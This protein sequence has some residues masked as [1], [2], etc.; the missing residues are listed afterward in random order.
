MSAYNDIVEAVREGTVEDV[1]YFVEKEKIDVDAW[2]GESEGGMEF[3][4]LEIAAA[5]NSDIGVFEYLIH[6][7]ARVSRQSFALAVM[8]NT[9]EIIT[10]LI[11]QGADVNA[12]NSDGETPLILAIAKNRDVEV[13]KCLVS[14][15]AD[16]NVRLRDNQTPLH[17][18]ATRFYSGSTAALEY[19]VSQ[20]AN[21]NAQEEDGYTPLHTAAVESP[22][23]EILRCLISLGADVNAKTYKG[24]T[25]LYF[26]KTEEKRR[27]LREAGG[28]SASSGSS[29]SSDSGCGCLVLFAVLGGLLLPRKL[30]MNLGK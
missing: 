4:L 10:Y 13:F 15:G 16:V 22:N 2:R 8:A 18:I 3:T 25:P 5:S 11:S 14:H 30:K 17:L 7:G 6:Q 20:G 9:I 24:S 27:L 28:Y 26:A 21:P 19:L 29:G 12:K 23:V 1:K